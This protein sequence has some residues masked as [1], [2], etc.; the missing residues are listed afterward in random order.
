MFGDRFPSVSP[1]LTVEMARTITAPL[2]GALNRPQCKGADAVMQPPAA[3]TSKLGRCTS[4]T[5]ALI[6]IDRKA[7]EVSTPPCPRDKPSVPPRCSGCRLMSPRATCHERPLRLSRSCTPT[8]TFV[9]RRD[10]NPNIR[11]PDLDACANTASA[12]H[13]VSTQAS[14]KAVVP[15]AARRRWCKTE[16]RASRFDRM[17]RVTLPA[18]SFGARSEHESARRIAGSVIS[19]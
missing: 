7:S 13:R 15:L 12:N 18:C 16:F 10:S 3:T 11:D 8:E 17:V 19:P 6:R 14:W 1:E 2:Y 9:S 5:P 4:A